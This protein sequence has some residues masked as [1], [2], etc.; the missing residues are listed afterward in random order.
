MEIPKLM[1]CNKSSSKREVHSNKCLHQGTRK[2]SN[3]IT[4]YLKELKKEEQMKPKISWRKEITKIRVKINETET[5]KAREKINGTK[6]WFSEKIN[7]IDKLLARLT[8]KKKE[9]IQTQMK[10]ETY[11]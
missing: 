11:N 8:K 4:L 2:I 1:G 6:S 9:R 3:N 10:E 7:K 5:K